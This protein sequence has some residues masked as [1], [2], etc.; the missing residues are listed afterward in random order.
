[1]LLARMNLF[2]YVIALITFNHR[3]N[4]VIL[5][6]G[7]NTNMWTWRSSLGWFDLEEMCDGYFMFYFFQQSNHSH[8]LISVNPH[9]YP[10]KDLL[11]LLFPG[12]K[13]WGSENRLMGLKPLGY[14]TRPGV[15]SL[16]LCIPVNLHSTF[17][18]CVCY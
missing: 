15:W 3:G 2:L 12:V 9:N 18:H 7:G 14:K 10:L 13:R 8:F 1:M 11:F 17:P 4:D 16:M 6:A 5:S